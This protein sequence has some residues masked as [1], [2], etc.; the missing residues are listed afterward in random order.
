MNSLKC[1]FILIFIALF[2]FNGLAQEMEKSSNI[3]TTFSVEVNANTTLKE[4]KEIEEFLKND[5]DVT[6][7]FEDVK[8]ENQKIVGLKMRLVNG[9]QSF[10]KTVNNSKMPI[11][12]FK[13]TLTEVTKGAYIASIENELNQSA[14]G[15][16]AQEMLYE[17]SND[18]F[19]RDR[20][21]EFEQHKD[22]MLDYMKK[23]QERFQ[24]LLKE[25][26]DEPNKDEFNNTKQDEATTPTIISSV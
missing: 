2:S 15:F 24:P 16:K 21:L 11:D 25:F 22:Q 6:V 19:F 17:F 12:T 18:T 23:L 9:N 4:L 8:I 3:K 20:F 13:I 14:F 26:S 7:T 10:M 5:Y 1:T